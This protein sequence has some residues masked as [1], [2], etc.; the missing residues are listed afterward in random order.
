VTN[1]PRGERGRRQPSVE[2][3]TRHA[4]AH[5]SRSIISFTWPSVAER[6]P[7]YQKRRVGLSYALDAGIIS[8]ISVTRSPLPPDRQLASHSIFIA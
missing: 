3:V 2:D 1:C 6:L 5:P 4:V 7:K 8:S